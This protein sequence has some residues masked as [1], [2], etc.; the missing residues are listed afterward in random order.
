M[1]GGTPSRVSL[2]LCKL[3]PN[4][5]VMYSSFTVGYLTDSVLV[6]WSFALVN[7][8]AIVFHLLPLVFRIEIC[9]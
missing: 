8:V 1:A 5:F 6:Y 2:K 4:G 7:I 9:T 3:V